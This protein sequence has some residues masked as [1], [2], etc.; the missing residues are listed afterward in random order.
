M[1]TTSL[2]ECAKIVPMAEVETTGAPPTEAEQA[3]RGRPLHGQPGELP[4]AEGVAVKPHRAF[5]FR[6]ADADMR[7]PLYAH[8]GDFP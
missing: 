6:D 2:R 7:K 4:E 3:F 1:V 5:Q 8:T